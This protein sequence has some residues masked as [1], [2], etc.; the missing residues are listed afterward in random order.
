[1]QQPPGILVIPLCATKTY[2][3]SEFNFSY[4]MS[5]DE[6]KKTYRAS[7][8]KFHPD[9]MNQRGET[10]DDNA[11]A[12]F[13][14]LQQEFRKYLSATQRNST[15]SAQ[16]PPKKEPKETPR[17]NTTEETKETPKRH[18]KCGHCRCE[19]HTR[20]TC[21]HLNPRKARKRERREEREQQRK[22]QTET[23]SKE[24]QKKTFNLGA[25]DVG[26]TMDLRFAVPK[27][28]SAGDE[29]NV[30]YV[31]MSGTKCTYKFTLRAYQ[32]H[33]EFLHVKI[34]L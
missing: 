10:V 2:E 32:T 12:R 21:P 4:T 15:H 27:G 26:G 7:L 25:S 20:T 14:R 22:A 16:P 11:T 30:P 1:M 5:I 31:D 33:Y 29:V 18:R 8:L 19:G 23:Q 28:A 34:P 6:V 3:M 17:E 9:K 13:H 24:T